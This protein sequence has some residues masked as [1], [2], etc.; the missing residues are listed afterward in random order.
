M[1]TPS[2]WLVWDQLCKTL[3][4][5]PSSPQLSTDQ[6]RAEGYEETVETVIVPISPSTLHPPADPGQ[7]LTYC[8]SIGEHHRAQVSGLGVF[9]VLGT[10]KKCYKVITVELITL[11]N[12]NQMG[13]SPLAS[14]G[15][16]GEL[17]QLSCSFDLHY[18]NYQL[19]TSRILHHQNN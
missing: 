16:A 2:Y 18:D 17:L 3:L 6:T 5:S 13:V 11:M 8:S 9:C 10:G 12:N 1:K 19:P 7:H 14:L 15:S 4:K